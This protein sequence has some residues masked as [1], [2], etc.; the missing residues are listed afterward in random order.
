[1]GFATW[2]LAPAI[3]HNVTR[4]HY[5]VPTTIQNYGHLCCSKG[6]DMMASSQTGSHA[7][8]F[9]SQLS[10]QLAVLRY[11]SHQSTYWILCVPLSQLRLP[12]VQK[13]G[14]EGPPVSDGHQE[15]FEWCVLGPPSGCWSCVLYL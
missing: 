3:L 2:N 9:A 7:P 4:C 8:A 6:R 1:M 12:Y 5:K 14:C 13:K 15:H 11:A 10:M